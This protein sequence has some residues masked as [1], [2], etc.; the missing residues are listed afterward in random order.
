[1]KAL[2][3]IVVCWS[4]NGALASDHVDVLKS[5]DAA[6]AK[7][8]VAELVAGG[9]KNLEA[10]EALFAGLKGTQNRHW[11]DRC[12]EVVARIRTDQVKAWAVGLCPGLEKVCDW[13]GLAHFLAGR[14]RLTSLGDARA[15]FCLVTRNIEMSQPDA[16][17]VLGPCSRDDSPQVRRAAVESLDREDWK[18]GPCYGLLT[19]ML[20]DKGDL[21]RVDAASRL[22][23]RGDRKGLPAIFSGAHSDKRDVT[24]ICFPIIDSLIVTGPDGDH[25]RFTHTPE[26]VKALIG[27]LKVEDWMPRG[28]AIRLLGMLDPP[29][30]TEPLFKQLAV[31]EHPKNRR[32]IAD[33]LGARRY[34][35]AAARLVT[36]FGTGLHRSRSNYNWA[37]AADWGDIGDPESVPVVIEKLT[38]PDK[39][40]AS[41]A[42]AALSYAFAGRE[43]MGEP[44]M[45]FAPKSL[46]VPTADGKLVKVAVA[47][48]PKGQ[49]LQALWQA[50][51]NRRKAECR[52]SEDKHALRV[53][54]EAVAVPKKPGPPK[55]AHGRPDWVKTILRGGCFP[56]VKVRTTQ[57]H[58]E[59]RFG[60]SGASVVWDLVNREALVLGGHCGGVDAGSIGNWR[61]TDEGKAW[62]RLDQTSPVLDPLFAKCVAAR[63][64]VR[65]AENA[66]R[67]IFH[68]GLDATKEAEAVRGRPAAL[69]AEGAR[70]AKDALAAVRDAKASGWQQEGLHRA[71][72]LLETAVERIESTRAGF[73][74][75]KVDAALLAACFEAQWKLDEAADCLAAAPR[76]RSRAT[77]AYDPASRCFVLFGGDH[78]DYVL[79]DTWIYDCATRSWRRVWSESAP[80]ARCAAQFQPAGDAGTLRLAGGQTIINRL[81]WQVGYMPASAGEW[82]FDVKTGQW[83]GPDMTAPGTRTYRTVCSYHD[84][85][86]FDSESRGTVAAATA[87]H[88]ALK[89]N[90][91]SVVPTPPGGRV[92]SSQSWATAVIDPDRDQIY[93]WSGGHEADVTDVLP[94]YHIGVNRWSIGFVPAYVGKGLSFDGRPDCANHTYKHYAYDTISRKLVM[95]HMGGTSVY[96]PDRA[97]YDYTVSGPGDVPNYESALITT[98]DGLY[99]WTAGRIRR[100]DVKAREWSEVSVIGKVPVP[101]WDNFTIAYDS[102]RHALWLTTSDGLP[103]R[104]GQ[105]VWRYDLRTAIIEPVQP[106]RFAEI[107]R[108]AGGHRESVY[109]PGEDLVLLA[110]FIGDRQ[111]AYDPEQNTWLLVNLVRPGGST[112][113]PLGSLGAGGMLYDARRDMIWYTASYSKMFVLRLDR[114]TL[115]RQ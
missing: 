84:P 31:E 17:K 72:P 55:S 88:Q 69:L 51:W 45:R 104:S 100:F 18:S 58:G 19:V 29:E 21:V 3:A 89:P 49:A 78:G 15:A 54:V 33:V 90:T 68:S 38:S 73:A 93:Y 110:N 103:D 114:L 41:A 23:R 65:D 14:S 79:N 71:V 4:L 107:S 37:V 61:V 53:A 66:A 60:V 111:V 74:T 11:R 40:I 47:D 94:T 70:L 50:Y 42:A 98:P 16:A 85:R 83:S 44:D 113:R 13:D 43:V 82:T 32:R 12:R 5:K 27:L 108:K 92:M 36:L 8:A 106:A 9:E 99:L 81:K 1:M 28:T 52:W 64:P 10:V 97:D 109:L 112:F 26:D 56:P 35:P 101:A 91:W 67:N 39:H 63:M 86:W 105:N 80:P 2:S 25:P 76:A 46:V 95:F 22:V 30:A 59:R 115:E 7:A 20:K 34:R 62:H 48:A 102:K 96:D 87:W 75:G 6:T 24:N 77:V 57:V